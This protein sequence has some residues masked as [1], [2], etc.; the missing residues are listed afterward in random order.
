MQKTVLAT[1]LKEGGGQMK[2]HAI[3]YNPCDGLAATGVHVYI[4][5]M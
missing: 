5:L 1:Q 4:A 3:V 2:I